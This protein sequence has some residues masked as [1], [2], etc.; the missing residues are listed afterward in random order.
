MDVDKGG[1]SAS[2]FILVVRM[3]EVGGAGIGSFWL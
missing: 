1:V 3:V 2:P